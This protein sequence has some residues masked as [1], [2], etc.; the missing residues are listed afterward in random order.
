LSGERDDESGFASRWSRLKREAKAEA[1]EPGEDAE[2]GAGAE[3]PEPPVEDGRPDEEVLEELGLPDPDTLEPGDNF[4]GFMAKA[5]PARLRNRALRRLWISD[6]VLANLDE[7]LDYGE[8]FTD[9]AA[10]LENVQT[11]YQVGK[12]FVDKVTKVSEG[13]A[14][15][16]DE[17]PEESVEEA[18]EE[19]IEESPAEPVETVEETG[20]DEADPADLVAEAT[21]EAVLEET[22]EKAASGEMIPA[23]K[24]MRF[25]LAGE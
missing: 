12:G 1:P 20:T 2:A 13:E 24:R 19:P 25:R 7:L 22:G 15:S 21:P 10:M 4:S 23:R 11:A 5:V 6:P 18:P 17:A 8:D 3:Q 9:A 16:P 14:G